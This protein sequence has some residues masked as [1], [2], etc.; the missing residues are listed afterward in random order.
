LAYLSSEQGRPVREIFEEQAVELLD[1]LGS[2]STDIAMNIF[3]SGE[4]LGFLGSIISGVSRSEGSAG[5]TSLADSILRAVSNRT[6][7]SPSLENALRVIKLLDKSEGLSTDKL[8]V[9]V[10]KVLRDPVLAP[11]LSKV[12]SEVSTRQAGRLV[13]LTFGGQTASPRK[14]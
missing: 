13:Q 11:L 8:S 7:P 9:L 2:D 6:T 10:R 4:S 14:M 12:V 3:I 5:G 1:Q